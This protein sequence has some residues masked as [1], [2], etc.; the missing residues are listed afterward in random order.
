M[1]HDKVKVFYCFNCLTTLF[2][3]TLS[4]ALPGKAIL[5]RQFLPTSFH[6]EYPDPSLP[7]VTNITRP[8]N[9]WTRGVYYEGLMKLYGIDPGRIQQYVRMGLS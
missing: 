6:E 8:S 2:V 5:K 4:Q 9:I 1:D 7:I 3:S